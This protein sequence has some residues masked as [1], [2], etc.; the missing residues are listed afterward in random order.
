MFKL[1]LVNLQG[2]IEE[3]RLILGQ[4]IERFLL[5]KLSLLIDFLKNLLAKNL[6]SACLTIVL[7][8]IIIRSTR[9]IGP[10]S[11]MIL[12]RYNFSIIYAEI[13]VNLLGIC[14]IYF[15]YLILKK[16][17]FFKNKILFNLLI[18]SF[19]IGFFLRVYTLQFGEFITK[20]S[21]ILALFFPFISY[22]FIKK[23]KIEKV[24][25]TL[26]GAA[27]L[28][29]LYSA[30]DFKN[31]NYFSILR[32]DIFPVFLIV[33][34]NVMLSLSKH[35]SRYGLK[36]CFDKLSMTLIFYSILLLTTLPDNYDYRTIFY[37]IALSLIAITIH[38][39]RN[40]INWR[41]DALIII[42]LLTV[43]QFDAQ[44][45]FDI[46]LYFFIPCLCFYIPYKTLK[47]T[48]QFNRF[49]SII[50][51]TAISYILSLYLAAIFGYN[52]PSM[53]Y[54]SPNNISNEILQTIT[55]YNENDKTAIIVTNHIYSAFPLI[56]YAKNKA[57]YTDQELSHFLLTKNQIPSLIFIE[58][59]NYNFDNEC[60][61][62][63][64]EAAFKNSE[65]K[66]YFLQNYIFLNRLTSTKSYK[67]NI[68]FFADRE[69]PEISSN[70]EI[71]E[72][73]FEVY[74]KK[75]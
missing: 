58:K 66:K 40:R 67:K 55:K 44:N 23:N 27:L 52:S 16:S 36:S 28:Y 10:S 57:I 45:F 73:D 7:T 64:L 8:S 75:Q 46:A 38:E 49:D 1:D 54:K 48:R 11:G 43:P 22:Q 62:G 20:S 25:A 26:F 30:I 68:E 41:R 56:N 13:L 32:E 61:I 71:I 9:D 59:K 24:L 65:F 63:F 60:K 17:E 29:I 53:R 15:S 34:F 4:K 14:S 31:V 42:F 33:S 37:S 6:F 18:T 21:L 35:D 19:A 70:H 12:F 2:N 5:Q 3:K 72:R 51:F 47:P 50:F 69:I 74:I 39:I